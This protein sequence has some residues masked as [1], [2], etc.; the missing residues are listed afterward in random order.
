MSLRHR[1]WEQAADFTIGLRPVPAAAWLEGGE[2]DPAARKDALF[3]TS[4]DLVWAETEGSRPGQREVL[5]LV[6]AALGPSP[7]APGL[8]PLYAAARRVPDDLCLMERRGGAWRLTALSL[9][10]GSFF[11][12]AEVVGRSLKELHRPVT[13]FSERFL[14][15]VNR[16]FEGLRPELVLERRNWTLT[17][18]AE[19]HVPD[20][21]PIRARIGAIDPSGAARALQLRVERQTLRRLPETGGAV[22][23]IRVW[24][25]PLAELAQDREALAAFARAWRAAPPAFRAY[26]R[27]DLYDPLVAAVFAQAGLVDAG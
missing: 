16:I 25:A 12:A 7:P 18:S 8:P 20:P 1:P 6:E 11:T 13:G 14:T 4:R 5:G 24:L 23:G 10:A 19:L 2:A 15:R 17:N 26:K 3:E 9:S 27:L 21:A 22:F